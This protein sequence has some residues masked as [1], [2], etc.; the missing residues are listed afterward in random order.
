MNK[1]ALKKVMPFALTATILL[2]GCG[3]KSGCEIP[4]SHVHKYTKVVTDDITIEAYFDDEH[5]NL[6]GYTWNADYI[7]INKVDE[8]LYKA[9][10]SKGL[11]DGKTNWDYL[12]NQMAIHHDYLEFYYEYTAVESYTEV[13]SE[14]NTTVKTRTVEHD[15]WHT[16]PNDLN[17]TGKTRLNH[18]RYYGY[19]VI[20]K[21]GKFKLEQSPA[22][23]DIREI[24]DDYPYFSEYCVTEVYK[25]FN[26]NRSELKYLSPDDFDTFTAP[27]LENPNLDT[28]I[29]RIR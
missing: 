17:N 14:G 13:D 23:D 26:F 2:S 18:H 21:D 5:L 22:V 25:T 10:Y 15:G 3:K 6:S 8:A 12:Y 11:F 1:S 9:L 4:T 7:E 28:G 24:I 29:S 16:D 20:Y 27:D 19:R